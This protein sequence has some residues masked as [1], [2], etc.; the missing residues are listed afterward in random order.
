MDGLIFKPEDHSYWLNGERLPGV[1]STLK[2]IS[3]YDKIPRHILDKAAERGTAVHLACELHDKGTL[4]YASLDD[5]ILG[6]LMGYMAFLDDKKPE[7]IGIE[8]PIH[9]PTLL[10]AGTYD[11]EL[12]LDGHLS[13]LDLKSSWQMMPATG[14][15][16]AA[17]AEA[18][19]AH[20]KSKSDH[21]KRR[22][23]L[24]LKPDGTYE[25]HQFKETTDWNTFLSCLNLVRWQQKHQK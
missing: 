7:I 10:Y 18:Q 9:H 3:G 19:N 20:R 5:E 22:Y 14:P 24:K 17:Y 4:D 12:I 15:Q 11:R 16:T 1:T 21:V 23:G 25:L 2:Y 8:Q 6:Y 13:T